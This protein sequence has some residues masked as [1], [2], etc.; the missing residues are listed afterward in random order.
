MPQALTLIAALRLALTR[1][2]LSSGWLYLSGGPPFQPETPCV[3]IA[4]E[5]IDAA[6]AAPHDLAASLG[7]SV[8]GLDTQSL[9]DVASSAE[10]FALPT[11]DS[12]LVEAFAYYHRW[13]AFLPCPGAPPPLPAE[14]A[15]SLA[16]QR[17]IAMLGP[18][19]PGTQCR[20]P[21]CPRG[22][23]ALSGFCAEHHYAQ[24]HRP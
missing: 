24:V 14:A 19:L 21:S 9:E 18:E 12:L 2:R 11:P 8:E 13:D 16:K 4:D 23:V 6:G 20:F 5:E 3:L 17:F 10:A 22:T 1:D 15:E 7:F